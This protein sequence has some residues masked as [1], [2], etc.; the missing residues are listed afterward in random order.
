MLSI[1][2]SKSKVC[3]SYIHY[4]HDSTDRIEESMQRAER[5]IKNAN[6]SAWMLAD[7]TADQVQQLDVETCRQKVDT[8]LGSL[9]TLRGLL[10]NILETQ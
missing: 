9:R 5:Q 2:A 3:T 10:D 4:A 1:F 7:F 8:L 6:D